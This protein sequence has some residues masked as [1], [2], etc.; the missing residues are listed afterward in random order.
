[1]F[2]GKALVHNRDYKEL[3]LIFLF[4]PPPPLHCPEKIGKNHFC[5]GL[6]AISTVRATTWERVSPSM[7]NIKIWMI[8]LART[9]LV[10]TLQRVKRWNCWKNARFTLFSLSRMA[11]PNT[12]KLLYTHKVAFIR[13]HQRTPVCMSSTGSAM[14][15]GAHATSQLLPSA[16]IFKF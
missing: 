16:A 11:K 9:A 2:R 3:L 13:N 5:G 8:Y 15:C 12:C 4:Q 10:N 1:M 14:W 7:P 6:K